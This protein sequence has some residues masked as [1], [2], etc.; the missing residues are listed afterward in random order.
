MS[1][2]LLVGCGMRGMTSSG[3]GMILIR[4]VASCHKYLLLFSSSVVSDALQPQGLQH[5]RLPCPSP[6]PRACSNSSPLSQWCHPTIS[7][8]ITSFSSSPQSFPASGSFPVSQLFTSG[9]QSTGAS[10]STPALPRNIQGWLPLGWTGLISLPSK[11]HKYCWTTMLG[12]SSL[13]SSSPVFLTWLKGKTFAL[14]LV[15]LFLKLFFFLCGSFLKSLLNLSQ[16]SF[17]F[18]F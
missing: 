6:S 1:I 16:E 12:S 8:S 2:F 13:F 5:A 17:C 18:M 11:G 7:S 14:K 4:A 9:G 15:C 3:T 10:A